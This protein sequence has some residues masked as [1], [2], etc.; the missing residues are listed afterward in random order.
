MKQIVVVAI[1]VTI[2][3]CA[4][5]DGDKTIKTLRSAGY[6][7]ITV[8]GYNWFECGEDDFS[9][10][11]FV[12]KNPSGQEVIGTVCCGLWSKGCTIRF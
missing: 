5:V 1:F 3:V 11:G 8:T 10:T 9:H 2:M 4:C 7:D 12:A 6:S